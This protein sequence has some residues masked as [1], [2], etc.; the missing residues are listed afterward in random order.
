MMP[1]LQSLRRLSYLCELKFGTGQFLEYELVVRK[2]HHVNG[3]RERR[4]DFDSA[5]I[6]ELISAVDFSDEHSAVA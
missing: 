3:C 6:A 1:V 5:L 4:L 2:F